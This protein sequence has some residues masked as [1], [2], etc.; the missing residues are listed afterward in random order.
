MI[1]YLK[2]LCKRMFKNPLR[3][4]LKL[5]GLLWFF[6]LFQ[7]FLKVTFNYWQPYVIPT[8]QLENI[9]NFIDSH[10]WLQIILNGIFYTFNGVMLILCGIQ[11]FWFKNKRD[12]IFAISLLIIMYILNETLY[13]DNI[14]IFISCF[15]C[16][17]IL[18][19]KKWLWIIIS[20]L[21]SFVFL[22]LSL[23]LEGFSNANNMNYIIGTFLQTDYY[24]MLLLNY[25]LFNIIRLKKEGNIN[26]R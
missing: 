16:P 26:G 6:L 20:F 17:L 3:L 18:D 13:L 1:K 23:F 2:D 10:R 8:E 25:I 11:R 15:I 19:R 9:G 24:I 12:T 4:T 5:F 22:T 21:C 14:T 7:I